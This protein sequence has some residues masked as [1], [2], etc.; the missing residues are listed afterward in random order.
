M[1]IERKQSKLKVEMDYLRPSTRMSRFKHKVSD[2]V[3]RDK[4]LYNRGQEY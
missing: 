1:L 2:I 4:Y 3:N